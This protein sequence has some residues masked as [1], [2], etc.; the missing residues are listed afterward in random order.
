MKGFLAGYKNNTAKQNQKKL[1]NKNKNKN[2]NK[3]KKQKSILPI[4]DE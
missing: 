4:L 1:K 3:T 2:K